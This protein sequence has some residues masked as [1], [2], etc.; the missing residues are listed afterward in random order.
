MPTVQLTLFL[1]SQAYY[2]ASRIANHQGFLSSP[3]CSTSEAINIKPR[4]NC[5]VYCTEGFIKDDPQT[6]VL[7]KIVHIY[8]V[9]REILLFSS[10]RITAQHTT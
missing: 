5:F 2:R 6:M 7:A 8:T 4:S 3:I 1:S 9:G 10:D